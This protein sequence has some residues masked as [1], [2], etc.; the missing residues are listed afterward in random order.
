[1]FNKNKEKEAFKAGH[2]ATMAIIAILSIVGTIALC[3][4]VKYLSNGS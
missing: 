4:L 2:E 1:M 3:E